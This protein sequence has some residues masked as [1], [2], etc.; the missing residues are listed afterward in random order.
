MADNLTVK[1]GSSAP[2]TEPGNKAEEGKSRE[3]VELDR[4]RGIAKKHHGKE[5]NDKT[6]KAIIARRKAKIAK[7]QKLDES[8]EEFQTDQAKGSQ[9][10]QPSI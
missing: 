8:K 5:L 6:L 9:T 4:L 1:S 7:A 3:Q 2:Q 10:S